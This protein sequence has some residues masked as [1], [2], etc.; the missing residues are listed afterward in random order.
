ML[1]VTPTSGK[2]SDKGREGYMPQIS[3]KSRGML[4]RS[5]NNAAGSEKPVPGQ[6]AEH[7]SMCFPFPG[8]S[9]HRSSRRAA[10][11]SRL[12]HRSVVS[13]SAHRT[14]RLAIH[15]D[16]HKSFGSQHAPAPPLTERAQNRLQLG[17]YPCPQMHRHQLAPLDNGGIPNFHAG[18]CGLRVLTRESGGASPVPAHLCHIHAN[19]PEIP[20]PAFASPPESCR[21]CR[22]STRTAGQQIP[23]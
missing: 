7:S 8:R 6:M 18:G 1:H 21:D 3:N 15:A 2:P 11:T 23:L 12:C 10:P 22:F 13:Q 17:L 5:E 14:H 20:C 9:P 16:T 19:A 4:G